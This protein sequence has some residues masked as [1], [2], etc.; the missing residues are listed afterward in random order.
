MPEAWRMWV[1]VGSSWQDSPGTLGIMFDSEPPHREGA[2]GFFDPRFPPSSTSD[3]NIWNKKVGEVDLAFLRTLVHEAGH[4]LNLL[5]PKDDAHGV[6][7]GTTIMNQT[8]DIQ[9]QATADN[10]FP[11]NV[12]MSFNDHN[13]TAL[14]HAPD[15]QVKPGWLRFG[16]G[17]HSS[18]SIGIEEPMGLAGLN[19]GTIPMSDLELTL[20]LPKEVHRGEVVVA[21]LTLT[22]TTDRSLDVSN[23]LNLAQDDLEIVAIG[24]DHRKRMPR[25]VVKICGVHDIVTLAPGDEIE[26]SI[27]LFFNNGEFTFSHIGTYEVWARFRATGD[28]RRIV[29]SKPQFVEVRS[30]VTRKEQ[31]LETLMLDQTVGLSVAFGDFG[32]DRTLEKKMKKIAGLYEGTD[33]G[34]VCAM[35]VSNSL[36]KAHR[37]VRTGEVCRKADKSGAEATLKAALTKLSSKKALRLAMATVSPRST[38]APLLDLLESQIKTAGDEVQ[39]AATLKKVGMRI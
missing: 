38:Q 27:Q 8:G 25:D 31:E 10:R 18:V 33:T 12:S 22:N 36:G 19:T 21:N 37:D 29:E 17:H 14:I 9:Q 30:S 16:W 2:I 32:A 34:A 23:A 1:L 35:V 20:E 24:P 11:N 39:M 3:E 7:I 28:P 5:H 13:R 26:S 15:P 6:Q 4:T